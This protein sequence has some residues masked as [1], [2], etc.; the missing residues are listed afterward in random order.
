MAETE[1]CLYSLY[2]HSMH[3]YIFL[4]S[5]A[6]VGT[7]ALVF[8]VRRDIRLRPDMNANSFS[9]ILSLFFCTIRCICVMAYFQLYLGHGGWFSSDMNYGK[10]VLKLWSPSAESR[11]ECRFRFLFLFLC[12]SLCFH[13]SLGKKHLFIKQAHISCELVS[14][15][16][17]SFCGKR[18][19]S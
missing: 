17:I 3:I 5:A 12:C 9:S 1:T 13:F 2:I 6:A 14:L 4:S 7:L 10:V 11:L 15:F 19:V 16:V 18:W 8:G